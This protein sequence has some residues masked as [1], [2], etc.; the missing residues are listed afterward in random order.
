M[1][2]KIKASCSTKEEY[3]QLVERFQVDAKKGAKVKT[4]FDRDYIRM[5]ITYPAKNKQVNT[6][7][8]SAKELEDAL[9]IIDD[10]PV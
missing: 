9:K 6:L 4:I 7:E 2:I 1:S 5:Y 3:M 8:E 10:A